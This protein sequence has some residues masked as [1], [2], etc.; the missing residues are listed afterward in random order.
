VVY[1]TSAIRSVGGPRPEWWNW[2]ETG[3]HALAALDFPIE[4]SSKV[5][6]VVF[7]HA[8]SGSKR[9]N[10]MDFRTSW[11]QML[12]EV[13]GA[14]MRSAV[15]R[16]WWNKQV[17]P[18]AY[19]R[20]LGSVVRLCNPHG[21]KRY[22]TLGKLAVASGLNALGVSGTI[23]L[24]RIARLFGVGRIVNRTL[25]WMLSLRQTVSRVSGRDPQ[26][27][28]EPCLNTASRVFADLNREAGLG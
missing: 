7:V 6:A 15:S 5:G 26:G 3:W 14:A 13:R 21:A 8:D 24:A 10:S 28:E 12:V 2:T 19:V 17:L 16:A 11:F 4:F 9:M 18:T 25:D 1:R 23:T 27:G 22:T 20:F